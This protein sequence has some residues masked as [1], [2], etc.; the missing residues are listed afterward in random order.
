[1]TEGSTRR[2]RPDPE[3]IHFHQYYERREWCKK[4]GINTVRLYEAVKAVGPKIKDVKAWLIKKIE[5]A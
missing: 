5:E 3:Q 2:P 1:M 4:F